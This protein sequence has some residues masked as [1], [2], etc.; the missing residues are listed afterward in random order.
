LTIS[1]KLED[2]IAGLP[3]GHVT[4]LPSSLHAG[5]PLAG[6]IHELSPHSIVYV[7]RYPVRTRRIVI[8]QS[9]ASIRAVRLPEAIATAASLV[10]A[11]DL[12]E[13]ATSGPFVLD[14]LARCVSPFDR[15]RI[16]ASRDRAARVAE[17]NLAKRLDMV[18]MSRTVDNERVVV[19]TSDLIAGE[20]AALT[21]SEELLAGTPSLQTPW[22][23]AVVQRATEL[24]L[25]ARY[26]GDI[27][28]ENR[29]ATSSAALDS[30][31][32]A[33]HLRIGIDF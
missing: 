13:V 1:T 24:E 4:I 15:A 26:P 29:A 14:V 10:C 28:I 30:I 25:G 33:F 32:A 8:P 19:G 17:V 11:V 16:L 20:L 9:A 7:P 5:D 21:L 23:D 6:E 31:I 27:F 18:I 3:P 22:E 2:L 12:N